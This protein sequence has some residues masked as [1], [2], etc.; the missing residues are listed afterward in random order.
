MNAVLPAVLALSL[1]PCVTACTHVAISGTEAKPTTATMFL[2]PAAHVV[3]QPQSSAF[4]DVTVDDIENIRLIQPG[5]VVSVQIRDADGKKHMLT[6]MQDGSVEVPY[7]GKVRAAGRTCR[8]LALA[9][10]CEIEK[11]YFG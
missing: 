5:D 10:K 6:V 7:I 11:Q 8:Q 3:D 9:I 2:P 4:P 1:L